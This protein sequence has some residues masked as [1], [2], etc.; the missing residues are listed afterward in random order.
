MAD[1]ALQPAPA[2][3]E[4]LIRRMVAEYL[5]EMG[6]EAPIAR[7]SVPLYWRE[8]GRWPFLIRVAEE[9]V[10]FALVRRDAEGFVELA[11]FSVLP[12]H[13][14]RGLGAAAA[15]AVFL[16]FPGRWRLKAVPAA[17]RFWDRTLRAARYDAEDLGGG[18]RAFTVP[19]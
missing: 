5:D 8:A 4:P 9:T 12:A 3:A 13:R 1:V 17:T 14:N 18:W 11:E 7:S 19:G 16:R 15:R 10:G 6:I 2:E